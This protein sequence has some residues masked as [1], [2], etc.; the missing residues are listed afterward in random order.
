MP[1][2][3]EL[4]HQLA[5]AKE[6]LTTLKELMERLRQDREA[7]KSAAKITLSTRTS[8]AF[9]SLRDEI[10][11]MKQTALK[12][13]GKL[14]ELA[15]EKD[16]EINTLKS[17]QLNLYQYA[18]HI[19]YLQAQLD[20]SADTINHKTNK[21]YPQIRAKGRGKSAKQKSKVL[22]EE[23]FSW[24]AAFNDIKAVTE[25]SIKHIDK[26]LEE[27]E[28]AG[29]THRQ[30]EM[31]LNMNIIGRWLRKMGWLFFSREKEEQY[32]AKLTELQEIIS[33]LRDELVHYKGTFEEVHDRL[34]E[35]EHSE[36]EFRSS[37]K[38]LNDIYHQF[39][40]V[41][42]KYQAESEELNQMLAKHK[43]KDTKSQRKIEQ[44][45]TELDEMRLKEK[46]YLGKIESAERSAK[47]KEA[48]MQRSSQVKKP[49]PIKRKT[50]N[51]RN[52]DF[53]RHGSL[54]I[55]PQSATTM[56]NPFKY[57]QKK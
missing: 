13:E 6:D 56:F 3:N 27:I 54:P 8:P 50:E 21:F 49:Q 20:K 4:Y 41:E 53:E 32:K 48:K 12:R 52:Q 42:K 35:K 38:E 28:N 15:Y 16:I 51:E 1:E 31:E 14:R 40:E 39:I 7:I 29:V 37:V 2:D 18:M 34:L 24:V 26:L 30:E 10:M 17:K 19:E 23:T 22:I 47:V 46:E 57:S 5:V 45:E 36:N 11:Q 44:L 55:P 33:Q 25:Q 9:N 43:E